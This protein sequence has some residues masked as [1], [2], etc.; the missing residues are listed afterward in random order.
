LEI[1][2][3][4][5][6]IFNAPQLVQFISR[7]PKLNARD[8]ARVLFSDSCA[9]ITLPGSCDELT[10]EISCKQSDWQLSSLVQ[11]FTSSFPQALILTVERLGFWVTELSQPCS[12][13]DI[14]HDQWLELFHTFTTVKNLY[15]TRGF[16]PRIVPTLQELVGERVTEVLPNLQCIFLQD[17]LESELVPEAVRQFIAARQLSSRPIAISYWDGY[18]TIDDIDD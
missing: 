17:L 8:E 7:T 9:T 13:G 2:F 5:Q 15:L 6:L 3:F 12:Q 1:N 11:V 16:L 18:T 14:E 4:Y 10:L